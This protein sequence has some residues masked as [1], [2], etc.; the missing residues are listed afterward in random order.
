MSKHNV[1]GQYTDE[2]FYADTMMFDSGGLDL[3]VAG[4]AV[5]SA[6]FDNLDHFQLA[7]EVLPDDYE[8]LGDVTPE[9]FEEGLE[10][11]AGEGF[12]DQD[13][14]LTARLFLTALARRK[15]YEVKETK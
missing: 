8:L 13:L 7:Y 2:I 12:T 11:L 5:L 1:S 3:F 15:G 9:S 6:S 4:E 10:G 14:E